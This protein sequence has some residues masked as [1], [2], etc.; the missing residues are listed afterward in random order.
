MSTL[1]QRRQAARLPSWPQTPDRLA[2]LIAGMR[3][4]FA[5]WRRRHRARAELA[6]MSERELHDLGITRAEAE[7]EAAM[8]FWR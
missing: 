5:D 7:R 8:P 3:A 2:I 6:R 1:L 4:T